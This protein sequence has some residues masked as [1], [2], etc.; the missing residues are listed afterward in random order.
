M[1]NV[2]DSNILEDITSENIDKDYIDMSF[3]NSKGK[4]DEWDQKQNKMIHTGHISYKVAVD[5][6]DNVESLDK[7]QLSNED[8]FEKF[9][10]K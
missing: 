8:N 6:K 10:K 5:C 9:G 4:E 3:F 1:R 2:N 7:K